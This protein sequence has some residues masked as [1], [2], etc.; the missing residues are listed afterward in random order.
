[1]SNPFYF[2]GPLRSDKVAVPRN[3]VCKQVIRYLDRQEYVSVLV[4]PQSGKTTFLHQL[5]VELCRQSQKCHVCNANLEGAG[6]DMKALIRTLSQ[7]VQMSVGVELDGDNNHESL[8]LGRNLVSWLK[9]LE[10]PFI[11]LVDELPVD[12]QLAY[13]FLAAVRA[14]HNESQPIRNEVSESQGR[15]RFVLFVST[16]LAFF[17]SSINP[18]LSPFNI[19]HE[20]ELPDFTR[21][22]TGDLIMRLTENDS[23]TSFGES[24]ID[25]IFTL[26]SGHPYLT[27]YLCYHLYELPVERRNEILVSAESAIEKCG[28]Q[29]TV[30][31]QS[32]V[33]RL[34]RGEELQD[35]L[36]LLR[37]I[38]EGKKVHFM[39]SVRAVKKLQLQGCIKNQNGWCTIRNPIYGAIFKDRFSFQ[40]ANEGYDFR[41][42]R[43]AGWIHIRIMHD[44]SPVPLA[45]GAVGNNFMVQ[46]GRAYQLVFS[47]IKGGDS[48]SSQ[49]EGFQDAFIE[50]VNI[51]GIEDNDGSIIQYAVRPESHRVDFSPTVVTQSFRTQQGA[52][53]IRGYYLF[54]FTTPKAGSDPVSHE[55]PPNQTEFSIFFNLYQEASLVQVSG[56]R[57]KIE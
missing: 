37:N 57:L 33:E 24:M 53:P 31:V 44:D 36:R 41:I 45:D 12:K 49:H 43:F 38:L 50:A 25:R 11:F 10:P 9:K 30:N 3:N 26:T 4:P 22:E 15:H 1:M 13:R 51:E 5:Q 6:N 46:W 54:N 21:E 52:G 20:V 39:A 2:L 19:A 8:K 42:R 34:W 7:S 47:L 35:E 17:S 48:S 27:Q 23:E 18:H 40:D 56:I 32:M 28:I 16:D 14:Y 29:D 55:R